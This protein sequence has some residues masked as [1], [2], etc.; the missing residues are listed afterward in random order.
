M[1]LL[2]IALSD[3]GAALTILTIS[4]ARVSS[5]E[6]VDYGIV[7]TM[8]GAFLQ[9]FYMVQLLFMVSPAAPAHTLRLKPH[10][11]HSRGAVASS[12]RP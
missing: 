6:Q 2:L 8:Q 9:F 5:P 4:S 3:L 10:G 7:C 1:W 12:S 11:A